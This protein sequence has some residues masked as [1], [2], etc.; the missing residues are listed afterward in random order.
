MNKLFILAALLILFFLVS[1]ASATVINN[2]T[3]KTF[4]TIQNAI[5]DT[6]TTNGHKIIVNQGI[7][8]E[9]INIYK[10]L[11][12]ISNGTVIITARNTDQSTVSITAN[13][14]VI[15]G[16]TITN[17]NC[18]IYLKEVNKCTITNNNMINNVDGIV[19][20]SSNNNTISAN[21]I[22]YNNGTGISFECSNYNM[23]SKNKI[24]N[25]NYGIIL[26]YSMSNTISWNN[27]TNN[28]EKG[29][30]LGTSLFTVLKGNSI[31]NSGYGLSIESGDDSVGPFIQYIDTSNTIDDKK[32]Y[33]LLGI[34]NKKYDS[35]SMGY[36]A[37][38]NCKNITIKNVTLSKN[39]QG[40]AIVNTT[41]PKSKTAA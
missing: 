2:N 34:A 11:N 32:I 10:S 8:T 12:L 31:K 24:T 13:G 36:L 21:R 17:G 38:V 25:N 22:M 23:I 41:T 15:T 16:F 18:G 14:T 37:L 29:I 19:G 35:L 40:I 9:N 30:L 28:K 33:Y 1:G 27:I 3:K 5:D 20:S 6:Q 26:G 39:G 4:S 7:Y